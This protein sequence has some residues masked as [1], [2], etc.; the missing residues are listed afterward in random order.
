MKAIGARLPRYDGLAHVTGRTTYVDDVR[1]PGI[2]WCKTLRSP[3]DSAWVRRIDT[4]AAEAMDG[5]HAVITHADPARNVVG[6]LEDVGV[7]PDLP[8]LA[9]DEVRYK[10]QLVAAVAADTQELAQQAVERIDVQ[11][12]EREA[13]FDVRKALDPESPKVAPDGNLF[14]YDPFHH[15]RVRKGDVDWA[16]EQ[17]DTIVTGVYRPQAIEQAP[18]EPQVAL[19]VPEA[20]GRITVHSTTQA[21]YFS[22]NIVAKYLGVAFDQLK[23]VGGTVGGGFGGKVD[24]HCEPVAALLARKTGRPV[25]YRATREEEFTALWTRAP[26]HIEIADAVTHDGW[27]LGR[28]TLTLHDAGAYTGFSGYG[29][30]KHLHHSAGAYTIPNVFMNSYVVYTNRVPTSAMRGF[31]VTSVS[32][33][34]ETHLTRIAD[35]LG[36]DPWEIRLKNGNRIG[37]LTPTRVKLDDPSTL[38]TIL[39]CADAAGVELAPEYAAMTREERSGDLL[40]EH[41]RDQIGKADAWRER[42]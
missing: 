1:V 41:L 9:E 26:W 16:F 14:F 8:L 15:C 38:P 19:A 18:I 34:T 4:S 25:K 3:Y 6:H 40:P 37:D 10:G 31:G 2:L 39:A 11:Y 30:M 36:L 24:T 23:F 20:D 27:I 21:M 35:E 42:V 33:A 22:M 32:F 7:P 5:V 17:A 12:E 29:A 13:L 28:R